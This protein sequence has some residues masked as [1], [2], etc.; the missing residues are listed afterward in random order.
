MYL[1]TKI[2]TLNS[3]SFH[4]ARGTLSHYV[5]TDALMYG[6]REKEEIGSYFEAN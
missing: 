3:L 5:S 1:G 4:K 2:V 6:N